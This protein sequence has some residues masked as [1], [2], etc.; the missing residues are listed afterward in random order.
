VEV[1]DQTLLPHRLSTRRLT[2][3]DE[4]VRAIRDM[5]V[6]GAPLIGATAAYGLAIALHARADDVGLDE[7]YAAL[8][9]ARPTAVNLRR[10]LDDL[11]AH[12]RP[13]DPALRASAAWERA[14]AFCEED[15]AFD[16]GRASRFGPTRRHLDPLQRR[17]AG[18]RRLGHRDGPHLHG[19]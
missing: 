17:L 14:D 15:V 7:A 18:D 19:A 8:L 1:I 13:L 4:A 11:R 16:R 5:V 10:A 3:L 6:R 12:V 2:S 9:A